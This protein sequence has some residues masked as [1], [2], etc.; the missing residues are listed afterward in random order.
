MAAKSEPVHE[1]MDKDI[2]DGTLEESES[3][4]AMLTLESILSH[5][6]IFVL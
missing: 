3:Q 1:E 6:V 5:V 4:Q 2:T